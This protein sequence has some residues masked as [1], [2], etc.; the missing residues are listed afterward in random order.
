MMSRMP[1]RFGSASDR[2]TH[3]FPDSIRINLA[4]AVPRYRKGGAYAN[5]VSYLAILT[6][7]RR[8]LILNLRIVHGRT[9]GREKGAFAMATGSIEERQ[10]RHARMELS[11]RN[12]ERL[13]AA[14]DHEQRSISSFIRIAVL[15][16]VAEIEAR[17]GLGPK[18]EA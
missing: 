13:R 7:L 17:T 5:S 16:R 15:D 4:R 12:H 3:P 18:S 11:P 8:G 1:T 9:G 2:G 14:A 6:W 10:V